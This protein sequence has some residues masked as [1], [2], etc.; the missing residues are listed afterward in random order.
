MCESICLLSKNSAHTSIAIYTNLIYFVFIVKCANFAIIINRL[1]II[2]QAQPMK[3]NE[4][5]ILFSMP[6]GICN[7]YELMLC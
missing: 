3:T 1:R 6:Y 2:S 4:E 7:L 5:I